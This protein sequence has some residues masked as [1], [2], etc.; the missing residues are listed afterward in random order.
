MGQI[1]EHKHLIVRAELNNPPKCAEA[2]QEWMKSLV[3]TAVM[4]VTVIIK[5]LS[6]QCFEKCTHIVS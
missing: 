4:I 3:D 5:P 6:S 2:I 1:L